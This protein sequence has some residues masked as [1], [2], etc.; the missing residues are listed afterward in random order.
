[1]IELEGL[2]QKKTW[3]IGLVDQFW[4]IIFIKITL[5]FSLFFKVFGVN[6]VMSGKVNQIIGRF[7]VVKI[8][9]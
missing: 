3:V 6:L 2:I 4:L 7:I 5:F 8:T 9:S 1:L